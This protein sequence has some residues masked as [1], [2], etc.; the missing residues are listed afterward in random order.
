[1][2]NIKTEG[3]DFTPSVFMFDVFGYLKDKVV[4]SFF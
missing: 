2:K 3:G 1:M 4:Y